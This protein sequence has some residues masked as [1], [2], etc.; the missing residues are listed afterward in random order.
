MLLAATLVTTTFLANP[1]LTI[2][3]VAP[4]QAVIV[5]SLDG[6]GDMIQRVMDSPSAEE[7]GDME[8]MAMP[9][10]DMMPEAFTDSWDESMKDKS[11]KDLASSMNMGMAV[12]PVIDQE[13]TAVTIGMTMFFGLGD[14]AAPVSEMWDEAMKE[15][16]E[17]DDSFEWTELAGVE[18]AKIE[19]GADDAEEEDPFGGGGMGP[20]G[21]SISDAAPDRMWVAKLDTHILASTSR[22]QMERMI[23]V[24]AG[25]DVE[26]GLA[27]TE[28]WQ[29]ISEYIGTDG[30]RL[31]M[32]TDHL[33]EMAK[34]MGQPFIVDMAK[35]M[36]VAMFGR[37]EAMGVSFTAGEAPLLAEFR[38][39]AWIPE[40]KSG[41]MKLF[42]RNS[43]RESMPS[44]VSADTVSFG[45]MNFDT[46]GVIPWMKS[47]MNSNPMIAMQAGQMMDQM[48]PMMEKLMA[49]MGSRM[50]SA[51]TVSYPL[52]AGSMSTMMVMEASDAKVFLGALAEYAPQMG[53]E[54]RD[55]QGHQ[56]Y[57]MDMSGMAMMPGMP[58]ESME[59]GV[60]VG[61]NQIFIGSM[62]G[63]EQ[64][65]RSMGDKTNAGSSVAADFE[66]MDS[67]FSGEPVS[68]WGV[69]KLG[70][71]M[72]A[73]A[74]IAMMQMKS[75]MAGLEEEDP[76]LAA[77]LAE[78]FGDEEESDDSLTAMA[79]LIG[80]MGYEVM[81][82][83]NGFKGHG[84]ILPQPE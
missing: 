67:Y 19:L 79:R 7:F 64:A 57:S 61:G 37:V 4:E 47:V 63:V 2:E 1:S 12:F 3:Q 59:M 44:W 41:L 52:N 6:L 53:M 38:M 73:E 42:D 77:E 27:E 16:E 78:M 74:E 21:M 25:R 20:M 58:A 26:G 65:L 83:D 82:D 28:A 49:G 5:A 62:A 9:M 81:S 80:L 18:V 66:A 69:S 56:I 31:V 32:L 71:S 55:F 29:G 8:D 84:W 36:V 46:A 33:G 34:A 43:P 50:D 11:M 76:E 10:M 40:G 72:K 48:E 14:A 13:T 39:G 54:P 35:P 23:D 24:L 30:I 17:E 70:E 60:A 22:T 68:V 75:Q 45:R 15:Y 51:T